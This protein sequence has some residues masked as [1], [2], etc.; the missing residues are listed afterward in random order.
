METIEN[1]A[2]GQ[3]EDYN[4]VPPTDV[5][6]FNELR[7]CAD[8]YRMWKKTK[9][10][11]RP[12]FQREA[13]WKDP[14]KTRFIDSL[15]KRLPIPSMCFAQDVKT[16]D[17]IVVDGLQRMTALVGF[18]NTDV[19]W[20]LST[21]DDVDE[22]INGKINARLKIEDE[23]TFGDIEDLSIPIN[24]IRYDK[25]KKNHMNYLFKIFQR[26]NS[27]GYRLNNQEIRNCIFSGSFNELLRVLD[28]NQ[29]MIAVY[30]KTAARFA[31]QEAILKILSFE[32][33]YKDYSGKLPKFLNDF[34]EDF[35][36]ANSELI[37]GLKTKFEKTIKIVMDIIN[38]S[39]KAGVSFTV[40]ESM[41]VGV[42]RNLDVCISRGTNENIARYEKML[43]GQYFSAEMIR[44]GTNKTERVIG[45]MD[46]AVQVFSNDDN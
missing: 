7:S 18:L 43:A 29:D 45:R 40:I 28:S 15:L 31:R 13:V 9:L 3:E 14:D 32:N 46:H 37:F 20:K 42:M 33:R 27:S 36:D 38:E 24:V 22:K 25:S 41:C 30:P 12:D 10:T 8:L 11:I 5:M 26:L 23:K 1:S 4:F 34:M 39:G 44:E 19:E 35:R 21:L 16:S 6:T 17:W 2:I